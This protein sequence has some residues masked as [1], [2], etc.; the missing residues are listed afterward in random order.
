MVAQTKNVLH[1]LELMPLYAPKA[2]NGGYC[3]FCGLLWFNLGLFLLRN[4][5]HG[6]L[7]Q[8]YSRGKENLKSKSRLA[9]AEPDTFSTNKI[10]YRS[11][12]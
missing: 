12:T 1:L 5:K 3:L 6:L 4:L 10:R 7:C 8:Q 9:S 11:A 2:K